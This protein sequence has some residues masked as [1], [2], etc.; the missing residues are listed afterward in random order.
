[1]K[2]FRSLDRELKRAGI[3][4]HALVALVLPSDGRRLLA[5]LR[6]NGQPPRAHKISIGGEPWSSVMVD[7]IEIVWPRK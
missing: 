7:G 5:A 3:K 1:M 6:A 4:N 2:A